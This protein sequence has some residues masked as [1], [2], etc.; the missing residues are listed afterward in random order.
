MEKEN[1]QL[2]II[3]SGKFLAIIEK[4]NL[5]ESEKVELTKQLASNNLELIKKAEKKLIISG[6]AHKDIAFFLDQLKDLQKKG[7]YAT[8]KL[9]ANTGSGK[10]E[11]QFKGGDTKLIIPIVIIA[12]IVL[13][14][15]LIILF[16]K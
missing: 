14:A 3:E 4:L 9:E 13:I 11:M 8:T 1:S 7:M 15:A 5:P 6:V 2:T 12:A 16:W 10:I